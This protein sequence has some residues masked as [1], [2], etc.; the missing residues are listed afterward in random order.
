MS[1]PAGLPKVFLDRSLGRYKVPALLR[2]EGLNLVTLAEV[3]GVPEDQEVLDKDWLAKAGI[4]GWVVFTKDAAIRRNQLERERVSTHGVRVF[5][6]SRQ[7]LTAEEMAGRFVNRLRHITH[8]CLRPGPF[9]YAVHRDTI[10]LL[11]APDAK[12]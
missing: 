4:E 1:H 5:C 7:G 12:E 11:F 10:E 9:I 6:L 3:Y 2:T 8:A